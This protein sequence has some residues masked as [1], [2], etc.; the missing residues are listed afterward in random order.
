MS[1]TE[2]MDSEGETFLPASQLVGLDT[3][4]G[5]T[6]QTIQASQAAQ[7]DTN[8]NAKTTKAKK[9][10]EKEPA[11]T[12]VIQ[13]PCIYCGKSAAKGAVVPHDLHRSLQGSDKRTR[14]SGKRGRPGLLGL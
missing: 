9:G 14:S 6:S 3:A 10:K 12:T 8:Q 2:D 13:Y 11:A 7:L 5:Q 1:G 4:T